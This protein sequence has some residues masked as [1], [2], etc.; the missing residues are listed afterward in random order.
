MTDAQLV[1]LSTELSDLDW[2]TAFCE[3]LARDR[4]PT[5]RYAC[6]LLGTPKEDPPRERRG[7][8]FLAPFDPRFSYISVNP[9]TPDTAADLP[10]Q[11]IGLTGPS[12]SLRVADVLRHFPRYRVKL[13]TYDGGHQ[14]FFHPVPKEYEFT[15]LGASTHLEDIADPRELTVNNVRFYFGDLLAEYRDGFA[16]QR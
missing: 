14:I 16:M 13:N 2:F 15:A 10:L 9:D 3:L 12:F 5:L 7:S 6:G 8:L 11:H 1:R 4:R